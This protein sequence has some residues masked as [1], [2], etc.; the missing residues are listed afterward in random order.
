MRRIS[1]L[2]VGAALVL[3]AG[4]HAMAQDTPP[5]PALPPAL[6]PTMPF[7]GSDL[8][9]GPWDV[10]T[11]QARIHV[12]VLA[13][14]LE[15][16]WSLAFL[17]GTDADM[18]VTERSGRLRI[19][20]DGMLDPQPI[21]GLPAIYA[22]GIAGLTDV[23]LHPDFEQNRL[24]YLAYSKPDPDKPQNAT[25]AVLRARWDGGHELADVE[26]IFIASPWYGAPPLPE[27]CCGQGPSFGS[28][29]GRILFD[30][31]G[32]L[33]ITSGDRNYG[34]MV[35]DPSNHFGK[36]LRL[37]DDG[38][39]PADNPWVG[40]AGHAPEVWSTGHRNPLGLAIQPETGAL[41]SSEFGPRG[42]DE[43]NIIER[44]A[45]YGWMS[46]TQ[47]HHYDGTPAEGINN[48]PGMTDPVMN[49]G[50]PS[51]NPGNLTFYTGDQF[52]AWQGDLFLATFTN[53][54]RRADISAEG[55]LVSE[56]YILKDLGQRWRDV[57]AGPD[58]NLYLLTDMRNGALLKVTPAP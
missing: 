17:P 41:W 45:N 28:F 39:V 3:A 57:R 53:G 38:S 13:R 12:E 27:R 11:G 8:G 1:A 15:N 30:D 46:V 34:E 5:P 40:R 26:D 43:I 55:Y 7:Q 10:I 37:H 56:E 4:G 18:L 25:L 6:P 51:I 16:P 52:P 22:L 32:Y 23:A 44:G 58:G 35:Q 50:P 2:A 47:G 24:I 21:A 29:G 49:F 20:R 36:I 48:V 9:E 19:V 31:E 54:I 14:G 33:F 42:G